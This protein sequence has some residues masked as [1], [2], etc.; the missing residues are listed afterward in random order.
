MIL[1][2]VRVGCGIW[3]EFRFSGGEE[4]RLD[5]LI[6]SLGLSFMYINISSIDVFVSPQLMDSDT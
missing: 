5:E 3:S 4:T 6:F 2:C 1:G